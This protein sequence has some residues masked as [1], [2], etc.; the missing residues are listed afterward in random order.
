MKRYIYHIEIDRIVIHGAATIGLSTAA[1]NTLARA[2]IETE[3]ANAPLPAG[4]TMCAAVRVNA[5]SVATGAAPEIARA[6]A[7][8][9]ARAVRGGSSVG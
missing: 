3:M 6:I 9:V 4:R 7:Y 8:G 2:A 5:P 1:V